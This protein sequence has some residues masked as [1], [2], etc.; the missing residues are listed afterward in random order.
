VALPV[1]TLVLWP[2]VDFV[3]SSAREWLLVLALGGLSTYLPFL[4]IGTA[5]RR[6]DPR[7][8]AVVAT[9]EPVLAV[10][11]GVALYGDGLSPLQA[12]GGALVVVVAVVATG[13]PPLR[14][15]AEPP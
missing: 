4:A 14:F 1:A 5:I 10:L 11:L 15:S 13:T 9:L 8:V 3:T 7:R 2:F 12:V 6:A